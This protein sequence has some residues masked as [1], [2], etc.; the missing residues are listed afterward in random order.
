MTTALALPNA[1]GRQ[2]LLDRRCG[3]VGGVDRDDAWLICWHSGAL[4]RLLAGSTHGDDGLLVALE[5]SEH[6][7]HVGV[8]R[9]VD[10]HGG[11]ELDGAGG[12]VR[13]RDGHVLAADLYG[14]ALFGDEQWGGAGGEE[15]VDAEFSEVND[16]NR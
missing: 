16:D 9:R 4:E 5:L 7:V 10:H 3:S 6:R 15:V 8:C 12:Q 2:Q 13:A 14:P 11:V 1:V